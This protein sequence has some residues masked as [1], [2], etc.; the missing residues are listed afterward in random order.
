MTTALK[1]KVAD[2]EGHN[3]ELAIRFEEVAGHNEALQKQLRDN[4]IE[5][6]ET[7]KH[8]AGGGFDGALGEDLFAAQVVNRSTT[9]DMEEK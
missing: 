8:S 1:R 2:A 3:R 5:P 9:Q 4:G 6:V 7:D